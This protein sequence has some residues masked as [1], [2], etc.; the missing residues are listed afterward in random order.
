[1]RLGYVRLRDWA[2]ERLGL[3]ARTLRDLARMDAALAE[4]PGLERAFVAGELSW[5]KVRLLARVALPGD[6]ARW[7]ARRL[8]VRAL[9]REV[10]AVDTAH[11]Q[12]AMAVCTVRRHIEH[13]SGRCAAHHLRGVH[14]GRVRIR[15]RAPNALRFELGLR[16]GAPP[17]EIY[18][19]GD[20]RA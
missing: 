19:S 18:R 16:P 11:G 9:E 1:L 10:R 4:L 12:L 17:L 6:E 8:R 14:A 3:S 7:L 5:A 13:R 20:V 2:V 15:G